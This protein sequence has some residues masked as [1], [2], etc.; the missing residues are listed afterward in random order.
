MFNWVLHDISLYINFFSY[1]IRIATIFMNLCFHA[2]TKNNYLN[3]IYHIT[4]DLNKENTS[5]NLIPSSLNI[6][7]IFRYTAKKLKVNGINEIYIGY[8]F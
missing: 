3:Y 8:P 7:T 5:E 1:A 2:Y 6:L 4:I